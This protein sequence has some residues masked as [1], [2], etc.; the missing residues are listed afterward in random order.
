MPAEDRMPTLYRIKVR[1]NQGLY[2]C[3]IYRHVQD[4]PHVLSSVAMHMDDYTREDAVRA[5]LAYIRLHRRLGVLQH[6][7]YYAATDAPIRTVGRAQRKRNTQILHV[8]KTKE[9][10]KLPA[11]LRVVK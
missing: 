5:A 9:R 7:Q 4:G 1:Q 3:T 6:A 10:P 11:F 2:A 8:R